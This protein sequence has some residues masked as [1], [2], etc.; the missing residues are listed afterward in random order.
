VCVCVC[1][2]EFTVISCLIW[3]RLLFLTVSV[4]KEWRHWIFVYSVYIWS[5]TGFFPSVFCFLLLFLFACTSLI[6]VK[7][8]W[9]GCTNRL[10]LV[11]LLLILFVLDYDFSL[12]FVLLVFTTPSVNYPLFFFTK[13]GKLIFPLLIK[14]LN[15]LFVPCLVILVQFSLL[16]FECKPSSR[17]FLLTC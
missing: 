14:V 7:V 2:S 10:F 9:K 6:H 13:S 1:L 5:S 12:L 15:A 16:V 8:V 4:C 17:C 3:S 11:T